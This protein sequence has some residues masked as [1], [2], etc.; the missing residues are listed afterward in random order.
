MDTDRGVR[1]TATHA[2]T[3]F[4]LEDLPVCASYS[5]EGILKAIASVQSLLL[6]LSLMVNAVLLPVG[7][8]L[9]D[10]SSSDGEQ[11]SMNRPEIVF[12]S[13]R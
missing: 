11:P 7:L 13:S 12:E 10:A 3:R 9:L 2:V 4:P 5:M 8:V 6:V 1:F